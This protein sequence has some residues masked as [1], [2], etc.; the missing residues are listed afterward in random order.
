MIELRR[1]RNRHD[2]R[3]P[4]KQPGERNLSWCRFLTLTH[5]LK[6]FNDRSI[7]TARLRSEAG[8]PGSQIA[9]SKGRRGGDGS[10]QIAH[11]ERTPRDKPNSEFFTGWEDFRLRIAC[12]D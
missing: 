8:E 10:G 9:S 12:P 4:G 3:L 2:P 7:R 6:Q 1:S 5:A 11:T